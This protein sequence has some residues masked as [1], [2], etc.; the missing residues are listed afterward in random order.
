[1]LVMDGNAYIGRCACKAERRSEMQTSCN[2]Q[3]RA[4]A[5]DLF[6]TPYARYTGE[7]GTTLLAEWSVATVRYFKVSS[8][9]SPAWPVTIDVAVD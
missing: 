3:I 2:M 6:T 7:R 4:A 5:G 8:K 1:M 9:F